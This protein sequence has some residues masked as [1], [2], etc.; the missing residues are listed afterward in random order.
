MLK[1]TVSCAYTR[2]RSA[3]WACLLQFRAF[4]RELTADASSFVCDRDAVARYMTGVDEL[5]DL[6]CDRQVIDSMH[7]NMRMIDKKML[8]LFNDKQYNMYIKLCNQ[9]MSSPIY[10]SRANQK[11]KKKKDSR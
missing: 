10:T 4:T 9:A 7:T 1:I 6:L 3:L 5:Q 11:Q 2:T 8:S